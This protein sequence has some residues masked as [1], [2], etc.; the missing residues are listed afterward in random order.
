MSVCPYICPCVCVGARFSCGRSVRSVVGVQS[1]VR[2]IP[3]GGPIDLFLI[4]A[5]APWLGDIGRRKEMFYLM[6]HS[7]H[8]IYGYMASDYVKV[9]LR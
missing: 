6:T 1:V 9:P 7:T 5:S 3:Y 4:P 8:F 2:S